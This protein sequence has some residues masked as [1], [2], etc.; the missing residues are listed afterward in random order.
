MSEAK[1]PEAEL[2]IRDIADSIKIID[3]CVKRG[4]LDGVEMEPVGKVR[5]RL[6]AF[7]QAYTE[8]NKPVEE[9]DDGK[10]YESKR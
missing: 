5:N 3:V 7:V 6:E 4:A 8:Q 2:N 10:S 1:K 9:N